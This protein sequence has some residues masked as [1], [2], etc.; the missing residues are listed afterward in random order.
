LL[1]ALYGIGVAEGLID[2]AD[3]G[4][5]DNEPRLTVEEREATIR[6]LLMSRSG[7][8][9]D[10]VS[11]PSVPPDDACGLH[12][13]CAV[14]IRGRGRALVSMSR[15]DDDLPI[16]VDAQEIIGAAEAAVHAAV[17]LELLPRQ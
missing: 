15:R 1:S 12:L 13:Q 9:H 8:Y 10:A 2:L 5:H 7:I 11:Y 4:I 14:R 6:D 17:S 3:L 16:S